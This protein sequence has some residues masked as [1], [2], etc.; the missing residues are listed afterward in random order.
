M[1]SRQPRRTPKD[2]LRDLVAEVRAM[3]GNLGELRGYFGKPWWIEARNEYIKEEFK[4]GRT[5][6]G[7]AS[8]LGISQSTV[9]TV[10]A[11]YRA[12]GEPIPNRRGGDRRS[13]AFRAR[14]DGEAIPNRRAPHLAVVKRSE[15]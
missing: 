9:K 4:A 12:A 8:D 10:I 6:R 7:I 1:T 11:R 13:A 2:L 3:R 15:G 14:P 5:I